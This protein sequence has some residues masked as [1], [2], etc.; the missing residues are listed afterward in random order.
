MPPNV[1]TRCSN[2]RRRRRRCDILSNIVARCV[3][4]TVTIETSCPV[5]TLALQ[6]R[7]RDQGVITEARK[8]HYTTDLSVLQ[9]CRVVQSIFG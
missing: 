1:D 6:R 5:M 9:T 3:P 7:D 4:A 8:R 2:S